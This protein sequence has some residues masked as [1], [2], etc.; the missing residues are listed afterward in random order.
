MERELCIAGCGFHGNPQTFGLCSKC[1]KSSGIAVAPPPIAKGKESILKCKY[2]TEKGVSIKCMC[3]DLTTEK[4]GAIVNAANSQLQHISGLAGAILKKGGD[5][6]QIESDTYVDKYGP[7]DEGFVAVTSSGT[8]PCKHIIHAVGPTWRGGAKG[9]EVLLGLCVSQCLMEADKLKLSSISIPGISSGIFG[10]PK[11]KCAEVLYSSVL[12][13][14]QEN[15]ATSLKEIRFVNFD[16][17]TVKCFEDEHKKRFS[18][19]EP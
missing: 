10:F 16:E 19:T 2:A 17:P 13:Y 14:L 12:A 9:E 18:G 7:V 8:L 15:P 5:I 11:D 1:F 6:I 4:T 3:G